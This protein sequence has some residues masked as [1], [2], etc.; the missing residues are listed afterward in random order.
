MKVSNIIAKNTLDNSERKINNF[1][2]V[3]SISPFRGAYKMINR[4]ILWK[5][6][7]FNLKTSKPRENILIEQKNSID[8]NKNAYS[9]ILKEPLLK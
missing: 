8:I 3:Y 6:P 2:N 1:E 4:K 9:E 7:F 5:L